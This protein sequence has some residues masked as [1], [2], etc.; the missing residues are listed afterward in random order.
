MCAGAGLLAEKQQDRLEALFAADVHV[1]VEV[2]WSI[3]QRMISA[4]RHADRRRGRA[5]MVKPINSISSGAPKS[6]TEIITPG[7]TLKNRGVDAPAYF[8]RPGASNGPT[9]AINGRLEHL[10]GSALGFR[11]LTN[12]T[13]RSLLETSEFR[14]RPHPQPRKT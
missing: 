2:T 7:R 6:L 8:D 12:H 4:H 9:E 5:S 3:H 11:T 10:R 1:E 14:P 13:A